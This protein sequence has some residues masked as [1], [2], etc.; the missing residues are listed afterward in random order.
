METAVPLTA[1]SR[2]V[3]SVPGIAIAVCV[4][5]CCGATKRVMMRAK[6]MQPSK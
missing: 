6:E 5:S 2:M 4:T 3:S 1:R